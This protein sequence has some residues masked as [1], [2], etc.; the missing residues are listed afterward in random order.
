MHFKSCEEKT[1]PLNYY[2]ELTSDMHIGSSTSAPP[3]MANPQFSCGSS[4]VR[5]K[6][7]NSEG[8]V[9][10][11][12]P[13]PGLEQIAFASTKWHSTESSTLNVKLKGYFFMRRCCDIS[14]MLGE[15]TSFWR[16][17]PRLVHLVSSDAG[18]HKG[19]TFSTL[20][21]GLVGNQTRAD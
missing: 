8:I 7:T 14:H 16:F 4:R 20:I 2:A 13:D 17:S 1:F 9:K 21:V 15:I 19:A 3:E 18:S 12:S 5:L 10:D 11:Y 6:V